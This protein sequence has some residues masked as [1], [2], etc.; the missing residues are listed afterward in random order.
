MF[1]IDLLEHAQE[2][3]QSVRLGL[4]E[5]NMTAPYGGVYIVDGPVYTYFKAP[6]T[7][8]YLFV[9]QSTVCVTSLSLSLSLFMLRVR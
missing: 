1:Q 9:D 6:F 5:K 2:M 8:P 4:Q 3:S 7:Q